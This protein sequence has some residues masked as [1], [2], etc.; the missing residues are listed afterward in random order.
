MKRQRRANILPPPWLTA[1]SLERILKAENDNAD[2]FSAPPPIHPRLALNASPPFIPSSTDA[3][4]PNALP[5]HWLELA[6]ILLEAAADDITASDAVRGLLRDLRE[7]RMAKIRRG[8]G[9]LEGGGITRLRGVGGIEVAE[10]RGIVTGVVDGL[11]RLG[12]SREV[13]RREREEEAEDGGDL[14]SDGDE[15]DDMGL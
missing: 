11:R 5:Y 7:T 15:D 6:E 12:M 14:E 13:A 1:S 3:S 4:L 10:A 8:M 9:E 2:A